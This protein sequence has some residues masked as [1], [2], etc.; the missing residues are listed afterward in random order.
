MWTRFFKLKKITPGEVHTRLLGVIDFAN[1]DLPVEKVQKLYENDSPY[2]EITPE[3]RRVL[4]GDHSKD[5][6]PVIEKSDKA[7]SDFTISK[8]KPEIVKSPDQ[9]KKKTVR[10]TRKTFKK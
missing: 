10:K 4:Y 3:G 7:K 2:L 9:S 8:P 5:D 1:P 6:A